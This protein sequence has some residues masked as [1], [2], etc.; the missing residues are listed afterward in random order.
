MRSAAYL[1]RLLRPL[2]RLR[3]LRFAL[4]VSLTSHTATSGTTQKKEAFF[5]ERLGLVSRALADCAS[6]RDDLL[7]AAAQIDARR[8]AARQEL[9]EREAQLQEKIQEMDAAHGAHEER[10][11]ELSSA[12]EASRA[13]VEDLSGQL[14]SAR[15]AATSAQDTAS[16]AQTDLQE[17]EGAI[18]DYE[19]KVVALEGALAEAK[20]HSA[21]VSRELEVAVATIA[22]HSTSL[23]QA[24]AAHTRAMADMEAEATRKEAS[25]ITERDAALAQATELESQVSKL[26]AQLAEAEASSTAASRDSELLASRAAQEAELAQRNAASLEEQLT[27]VKAELQEKMGTISQLLK[28]VGEMTAGKDAA[29]RSQG[30]REE[31]LQERLDKLGRERDELQAEVIRLGGD[32]RQVR[33]QLATLS[34]KHEA[35]LED[36]AS[37][38][39][40]L[41]GKDEQVTALTA[42]V[43][44]LTSTSAAAAEAAARSIS[45]LEEQVATA[46]ADLGK[47]QS[48]AAEQD[49]TVK[50]A[51]EEKQRSVAQL[52]EATKELAEARD[53]VSTLEAEL[54]A[55]KHSLGASESSKAE[56]LC[57]AT[58]EAT[59][60]RR[61][62]GS[63]GE[64]AQRLAAAEARIETLQGQL[65]R[66]EM[67][68]RKLH[69]TIQD[70]RGNIRVYVRVRPFLPGDE[71]EDTKCLDDL[72]PAAK[73]GVDGQSVTLAAVPAR[74][75]KASTMS[76]PSKPST[77]SFDGVFG[78]DADQAHVF[79]EVGPL[80]Q[81]A[82]DGYNVCLFS[83]GQTGSGK[84]HT[85]VG[86][87]GEASGLIPRSISK[88]LAESRRMGDEGWEYS[89][90]ASFL[91]IYNENIRDLLT[92]PSKSKPSFSAA[93]GGAASSTGQSLSV[94]HHG[95][96]TTEVPGLT[97]VDVSGAAAIEELLDTASANRSVASTAMNEVSSRSHSVF[98]L[99]IK[100]CH[101]E[102]GVE[103]Q[104]TLNLVDLAGS[105]R[106]GR[107]GAE[108]KHLKEAGA[109]NKSLS[110]L[111]D[112]FTS[113]GRGSGHIPFRNSKL[114]Y[115]LAPCFKGD[116]K[117]LMLVN[118]S[119][120]EAS[121]S[122]S[123]CSLRFASTVSQV[124]LGQATKRVS[125]APTASTPGPKA[126]AAPGAPSSATRTPKFGTFPGRRGA[127]ATGG[128]RR[129]RPGS[130]AKGSTV[131]A[132]KRARKL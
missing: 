96:G 62:M 17:A 57:A 38:T 20:A 101:A 91:E 2:L 47:A 67:T 36:L 42:Q 10:V 1:T 27:R 52:E 33:E 109:I 107:S 95:D 12:L 84:T 16:T 26:K 71:P 102:K 48:K 77:F 125:A 132:S 104:G 25:L 34:S 56:M 6:R 129:A 63:M 118:L 122:E 5:K 69:N 15:A 9:E 66:G 106:V 80:V 113:L 58:K 3:W 68:R 111:G 121:A 40:S 74:G 55:L 8:A 105:E 90:Q 78:P 60:L 93:G 54:E 19:D 85:M 115:L 53:T 21:D 51:L 89:L 41:K 4:S 22:S 44:E 39:E 88:I 123:L 43:S 81:S 72:V 108:G 94:V 70:L 103:V 126:A 114:T 86:G 64:V 75:G 112:V 127:P 31:K 29:M 18:A 23:S 50:S 130:A 120:T 110:A 73:P 35:A 117:T 61:Q 13:E 128:T 59:A 76:R 11:Q 124:H 116:G 87:P 37:K 45:D 28:T 100:G 98:T 7:S 24:K 92:A 32:L 97:L 131:T 65:F 83:Y 82:L 119:P 49:T 14:A 99:H 30:Q 46:K 79:N